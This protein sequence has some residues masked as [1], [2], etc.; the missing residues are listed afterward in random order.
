MLVR[1]A[2]SNGSL[3]AQSSCDVI[4]TERAAVRRA[5]QLA[6]SGRWHDAIEVLQGAVTSDIGLAA[7][8]DVLCVGLQWEAALGWL[9]LMHRASWS[10]REIAVVLNV[11]YK[12]RQKLLDN[13]SLWRQAVTLMSTYCEASLRTPL[14]SSPAAV[15]NLLGILAYAKRWR[16]ALHVAQQFL[17]GMPGALNSP[18]GDERQRVRPNMMTVGQLMFALRAHWQLGL[19]VASQ[20]VKSKTI[21]VNDID[22]GAAQR[23][24]AMC[25]RGS[26]WAEAA[27]LLQGASAHKWTV[28]TSFAKTLVALMAESGQA[29]TA[30]RFASVHLQRHSNHDSASRAV[31]ALV[32]SSRNIAEAEIWL[33]QLPQN[34]TASE[35]SVAR[36]LEDESIAHLAELFA[37]AGNW[38]RAAIMCNELM[39]PP[40]CLNVAAIT[41]QLHD[42]V[43]FALASAPLP[44]PTWEVGMK[45]FSMMCALHVPLS[46]VAF[47]SVAKKCFLAGATT[48][49]NQLFAFTM[50]RG[51][52][53][54]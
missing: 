39:A 7:G 14:F 3:S 25:I 48:Q 34:E 11:M 52:G 2:E 8:V 32:Q 22:V 40:R 54:R 15:S 29:S 28:D 49:A 26:R 47:Q 10:D 44:G 46:E 20:L 51:V 31:N 5:K 27:R 53:R 16:L 43:Q 24:L 23:I 38:R 50:K 9:A 17:S 36:G 45:L 21:D 6:S 30:A 19:H 4:V 42:S 13:Q 35:S 41:P 33:L 37:K 18:Y 1:A 12:Q